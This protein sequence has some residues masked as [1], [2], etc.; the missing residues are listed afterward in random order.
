LSALP[1][2]LSIT[3]R[4]EPGSTEV[5]VAVSDTGIGIPEGDLATVFARFGRGGNAR[6]SGIAGSGVG[7]YIAKKI[8]D[9]HGGRLEVESTLDQGSTF[10]IV[11]P[12]P[13]Q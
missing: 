9:V 13:A 3:A 7:L 11:V 4:V 6:S 12:A 1:T 2:T 5:T 10:R 8:V